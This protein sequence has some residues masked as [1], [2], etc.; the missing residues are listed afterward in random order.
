MKKNQHITNNNNK[1]NNEISNQ[2]DKLNLIYKMLLIQDQEIKLLK[3]IK[4]IC[5]KILDLKFIFIINYI[6]FSVLNNIF[7]L[8]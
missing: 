5:L 7:I 4:N 1:E 2:S 8:Y 3:Y 6:S